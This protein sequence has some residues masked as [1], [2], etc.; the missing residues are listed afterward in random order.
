MPDLELLRKLAPPVEPPPPARFAPRSASPPAAAA[1][2]GRGRRGRAR[3]RWPPSSAASASP[4]PRS[5]PPRPPRGCSS[6]AGRSRAWTSGTRARGEMTF[7]RD[8]RTLDLSLGRRRTA[9]GR[10]ERLPSTRVAGAPAT[11]GRFEGT[12][13]FVARWDDVLARGVA[14]SAEAFVETLDDIHQVGAEDWL[15][16]LPDSA[17]APR[18]QAATVQEMLR[19]IPLP[20]GFVAPEATGETR[21]RYQLGAKVAGAVACAWIERGGKEAVEALASSRSWPILLRDERRGRLPRGRLAVRR[22]PQRQAATSRR[23]SPGSPSRRATGRARMLI[24]PP[25]LSRST[26]RGASRLLRQPG[27][28]DRRG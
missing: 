9:Q 1:H 11:V 2:A 26:A 13:D 7:A 12:N 27:R 5:A 17:V 6:R 25:A 4:R 21:D 3:A 10:I 14:A 20:P 19:G 16:A 8:G 22:R 18:A 24:A 23:A 28:P 15:E